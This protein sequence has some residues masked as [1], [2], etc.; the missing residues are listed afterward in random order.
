MNNLAVGE[1]V[2]KLRDQK[3]L[4]QKDLTALLVR[5]AVERG[6]GDQISKSVSFVSR[7]ERG[8]GGELRADDVR[9]L[10]R[11]LDTHIGYLLDG[12]DPNLARALDAFS[13]SES[14]AK[15]ITDIANFFALAQQP[16]RGHLESALTEIASWCKL[17]Y[18][19]PIDLDSILT[20]LPKKEEREE[21]VV[22]EEPE[23]MYSTL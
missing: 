16:D 18:A 20:D 22:E 11:I 19:D 14:M 21:D 4:D 13:V 6:R 9:A 5:D 10:A 15:A 12:D 17:R 23:A 3:G 7:L 1:R 8:K 2:R